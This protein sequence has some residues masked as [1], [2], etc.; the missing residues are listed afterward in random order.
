MNY[1]EIFLI[2]LGLSMDAFA[3]SVTLGLSVNKPTVKQYL[4]PGVYF[5]LFQAIMPLAG[6]YAGTLFAGKIQKFEHWIAFGL[7]FFIGAKMV[8]DSFSKPENEEEKTGANKFLFLNMLLLAIATSIDALTVG[9]TLA[10]FKIN[11]FISIAIIGFTT[12]CLSI[13]GVKIGN[14][15]GTKFKS[16][17]EFAG[18]IILIALGIKILIEHF[19]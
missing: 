16:K 9:I 13:C 4:I 12:F 19:L 2:A 11:I 6:F 8:K 10:F 18:G 1:P 14:I 3:V 17:A 5:G 15:F 7:L